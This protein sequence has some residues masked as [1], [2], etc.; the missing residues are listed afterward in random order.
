M[1]PGAFN[2]VTQRDTRRG[3][4]MN[5]HP[6]ALPGFHR[7]THCFHGGGVA[8]HLTPLLACPLVVVWIHRT[9]DFELH[10]LPV[11]QLHRG[12]VV[13][14]RGGVWHIWATQLW[15]CVT[16]GE[17]A[18]AVVQKRVFEMKEKKKRTSDSAPL[19]PKS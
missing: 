12:G 10:Q 5:P 6:R 9:E 11:Q 16:D 8:D 13:Y 15:G 4:L 1:K 18:L 7:R 17:G 19:I 3:Q 2:D 14:I